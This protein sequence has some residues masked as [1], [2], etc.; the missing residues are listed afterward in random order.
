MGS[1]AAPEASVLHLELFITR[2]KNRARLHGR[3]RQVYRRARQ[4]TR[5]GGGDGPWL[6][7][8]DSE[9]RGKGVSRLRTVM[10]VKG[11]E[12]LWVELV[13]CPSA[14]ADRSILRQLWNDQGFAATVNDAERL[15]S[16]RKG[17]WVVSLGRR[18]KV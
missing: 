4:V 1:S 15:N 10:G 8:I 3:L 11:D 13:I 5:A 18:Q 7:R 2:R 17:G 14:R 6:F 12:D 9:R 16:K